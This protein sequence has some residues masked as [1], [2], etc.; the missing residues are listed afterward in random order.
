VAR[1]TRSIAAALIDEHLPDLVF[2]DVRRAASRD[3]L[4]SP[5][6]NTQHEQTI[7]TNR[8]IQAGR[9][10]AVGGCLIRV[11]EASI[12]ARLTALEVGTILVRNLT[13]REVGT[14]LVRKLRALKVATILVR[15]SIRG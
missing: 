1:K 14:T 12:N 9:E 5:T 2:L 4:G 3:S 13:A 10:A 11:S 7:Q 15:K 8:V 6:Y